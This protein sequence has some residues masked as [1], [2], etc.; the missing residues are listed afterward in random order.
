MEFTSRKRNRDSPLL[1]R[2]FMG[3]LSNCSRIFSGASRT[4]TKAAF[5]I[6]NSW[7]LLT[8][9]WS[10]FS[11]GHMFMGPT[12]LGSFVQPRCQRIRQARRANF[13]RSFGHIVAHPPVLYHPVLGRVDRVSGP[14]IA[15]SR[16]PH[17]SGVQQVEVVVLDL[18]HP[19]GHNPLHAAP[20]YQES[21]LHVR[22][23]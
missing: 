11:D 8:S 14:R 20:R 4:N 3:M 10:S 9:T 2:I 18:Q 15:V 16:L 22:V 1:N 7:S 21:S 23:A 17:R 19:S 13:R 12:R 5:G 6:S